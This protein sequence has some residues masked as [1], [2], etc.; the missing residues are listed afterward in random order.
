METDSRITKIGEYLEK[1]L[2][3]LN[4]EYRRINADFLGIEVNNYSLDKIPIAST[5]QNWIDGT[6]LCRDVYSFR[7]RNSYSS[8]R[9]NNIKNVGF[10]E[11]FENIIKSNNNEGIL[12]EIEGIEEIEC[13][14]CGSVTSTETNTCEMDIQIQ[15]TYKEG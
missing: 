1:I 6:S 13:L 9:M 3:K 5:I 8:D 11:Q 10:F 12:P 7:S 4:S 15:I 14:N 2:E